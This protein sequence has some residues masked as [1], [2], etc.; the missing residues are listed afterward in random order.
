MEHKSALPQL[1]N[2]QGDDTNSISVL[3]ELQ[4]AVSWRVG[5]EQFSYS[6]TEKVAQGDDLHS[7]SVLEELQIAVSWRVGG[8]QFSS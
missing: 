3:E 2:A 1:K 5:G 8:A 7:I 6:S 4:I